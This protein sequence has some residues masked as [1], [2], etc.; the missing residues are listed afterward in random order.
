MTLKGQ[1]VQSRNT[2]TNRECKAQ[3]SGR[4]NIRN[5]IA[6]ERAAENARYK[7]SRAEKE[8]MILYQR[9]QL[10]NRIDSDSSFARSLF[11]LFDESCKRAAAKQPMTRKTQVSRTRRTRNT[12]AAR[13]VGSGP[14]TK[15]EATSA[16]RRHPRSAA[17][18]THPNPDSDTSGSNMRTFRPWE[19]PGTTTSSSES[20]MTM[21]SSHDSRNLADEDE[22]TIASDSWTTVESVDSSAAG[23]ASNVL[24]LTQ[25]QMGIMVLYRLNMLY[26]M[27][28][29][30]SM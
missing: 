25:N 4:S 30:N 15:S 26:L 13:P 27:S 19:C 29:R 18:A 23:N 2:S 10:L 11:L 9:D 14:D 24:T 5:A 8:F 28:M 17:S 3:R 12:S 22:V 16:L 20:S 1:G 7:Q 6:E 21:S